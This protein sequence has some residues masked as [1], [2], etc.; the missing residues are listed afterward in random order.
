MRLARLRKHAISYGSVILAA[1]LLMLL[2]PVNGGHAGNVTEADKE[3]YLRALAESQNATQ[4]K[5]CRNLLA[6]VPGFDKVNNKRLSGSKIRWEGLPGHSRVLV[7]ALMSKSTFQKYYATCLKDKSKSYPLTKSLWVTVVPELRNFFVNKSG[8]TCPPSNKRLVQALGLHPAYDYDVILEFWVDPAH[9]FRPSADPEITDHEAELATKVTDDF[10]VFPGERNPF[11]AY[12]SNLFVD[13]SGSNP[14]PFKQWYTDRA[15]SIYD[16]GDPNDPTTWGYPWTRLG[17]TY[18]WGNPKNHVGLSE[19]VVWI[20]PAQNGGEVTVTYRRAI[21]CEHPNACGYKW[22]E[23]FR[24]APEAH[25]QA[26]SEE[27]FPIDPYS[28]N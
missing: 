20:D 22:D 27:S 24:C 21:Q 3:A 14:V 17:Y 7:A 16:V 8:E 13:H 9:L 10:W 11:V 2:M 25:S 26:A 15:K 19:F 1:W 23:Y 5:I 12:S 18:D 28:E 6:V 4:K